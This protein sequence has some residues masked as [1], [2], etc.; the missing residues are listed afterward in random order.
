MKKPTVE[1]WMEHAE[2]PKNRKAPTA[3]QTKDIAECFIRACRIAARERD[4]KLRP[5]RAELKRDRATAL[6]NYK[7]ACVTAQLAYMV[8]GAPA[9]AEY[10]KA[11]NMAVS[12][13]AVKFPTGNY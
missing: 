1:E 6:A 8:V 7:K 3:K 12:Q 9:L 2:K 5:A 4:K 13:C 11:E 10:A